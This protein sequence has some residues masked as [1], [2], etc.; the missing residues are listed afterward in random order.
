MRLAKRIRS[1]EERNRMVD[2]K[3]YRDA[4]NAEFVAS[5]QRREYNDWVLGYDMAYNAV[6]LTPH[7]MNSPT[8]VYFPVPVDIH[9]SSTK[10]LILQSYPNLFLLH[11][12]GGVIPISTAFDWP[13]N[14]Q[15]YSYHPPSVLYNPDNTYRMSF[16]PDRFM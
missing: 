13:S 2:D 15:V 6:E 5:V 8:G 12:D 10:A 7:F 1:F 14:V 3:A 9:M 11:P 4:K 16:N